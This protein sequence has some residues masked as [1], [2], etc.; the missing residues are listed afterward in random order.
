M[1]I[2]LVSHR[3]GEGLLAA[4]LG[5]IVDALLA[6]PPEALRIT[7]SLLRHGSREEILARM[8]LESDAFAARLSSPEVK[9]AIT[10]F[11]ARR[12]APQ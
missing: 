6:K 10:A 2:G 1:D 9:E 4:R 8:Q 11:F 5:E 12:S 3:A 7:Q